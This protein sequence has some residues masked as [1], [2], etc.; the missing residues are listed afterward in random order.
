M[1]A[2]S[3]QNNIPAANEPSQETI[4]ADIVDTK[5][6][7][8]SLRNARIYLYIVAALQVGVGIYQYA[9]SDP[10]YALLIGGIPIGLGI[11]F[12]VFAFWSYKKPVAAFMTALITFVVVHVL[13]MIDDPSAIFRGIILKV[14]VVV[15]LIKAY[16]DAVEYEKLRESIG[17]Q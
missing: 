5:P 1:E 13:T 14:L 6:Y 8:K 10:E 16:K 7:E 4:F 12:L 2:Q 11:L 17:E 3:R 15:A 9:N